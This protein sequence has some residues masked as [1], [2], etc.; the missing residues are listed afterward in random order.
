MAKTKHATHSWKD[1]RSVLTKAS[2]RDLLSLVGDLYALRK[3]NQN[4]LYAR[5]IKDGDTLVPF[6]EAIEQ[7]VSPA[8][9][10]KH[11]VKLSLARKAISDYR[12]A[13]GDPEGLAELMLYYAECGVSFTLDFGDIDEPFYNSVVGVFFDGLKMLKRCEPDIVGKLLP[14]FVNAVQKQMAWVG[15]S[16]TAFLTPWSR[17]FLTNARKGF[18]LDHRVEMSGYSRFGL[19]RPLLHRL[20][21]LYPQLRTWVAPQANVSV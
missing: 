4:F 1:I 15:G 7:Y 14:R 2:H 16:T 9:P 21:P 6:K 8:E 12:K 18:P 11:P 5:F 13:V 3:E 17:I 20:L 10:W 19:R